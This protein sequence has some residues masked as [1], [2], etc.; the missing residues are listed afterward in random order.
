MNVFDII[1]VGAGPSGLQAARTLQEQF[2]MKQ[3]LV[4]EASEGLGGRGLRGLHLV[5]AQDA[6]RFPLEFDMPIFDVAKIRWDRKWVLESQVDWFDKDWACD[7][8]SIPSVYCQ[9]TKRRSLSLEKPRVDVAVLLKRPVKSLKR[10]EDSQHSWSLETPDET[11]VCHELVWAA[12]LLAFQN[13]L[14][15]LEAQKFCVANPCFDPKLQDLRGGLS[16]EFLFDQPPQFEE[17]FPLDS[18]FGLPVRH[19]GKFYLTLG[20]LTKFESKPLV[21]TL[22]HLP[23]DKVD[24]PQW[25]LSFEKSVR[26]SLKNIITN[27]E[28]IWAHVRD[29]RV[30][31]SRIGAH[32]L[33]CPWVLVSS[34]QSLQFVGDESLVAA[35]SGYFDT[36]SA[37]ASVNELTKSLSMP[38]EGPSPQI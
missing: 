37:L 26:R 6:P 7:L 34:D 35:K 3:I 11:F 20:V 5:S 27:S 16:L 33:G 22:V 23:K 12:G 15:K 36:L 9:G 14:S 29:R 31:N 8:G 19:E 4:L 21:S 2:P 1:V 25:L 18:V 32:M 28:E 10:L 30:V 13:A 38:Q 24:D 17:G